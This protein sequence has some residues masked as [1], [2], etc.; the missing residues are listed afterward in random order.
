MPATAQ[1]GET[2]KIRTAIQHPMITGHTDAG[3]NVAPRKIIHTF[4]VAYLDAEVLR[5]DVA[6]GIAANPFFAFNLRVRSSG[7]VVFTWID[8]TGEVIVETRQLT[9]T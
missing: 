6:P 2:I 8:D 5:I 7:D 3:P 1:A 4:A 9:V